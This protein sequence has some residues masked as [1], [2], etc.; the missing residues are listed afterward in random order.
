MTN[1]AVSAYTG[2][3][4]EIIQYYIMFVISFNK[5]SVVIG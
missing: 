5:P 4:T 2:S 3:A 1:M